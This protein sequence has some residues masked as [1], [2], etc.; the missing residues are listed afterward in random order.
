[1]ART[2]RVQNAAQ[3]AILDSFNKICLRHQ[4]WRVWQDF[5]TIAA[6]DISCAVDKSTAKKRAKMR[7]EA[8]KAYSDAE[9]SLMADMLSEIVMSMEANPD[10]DCLGELFMRLELGNEY[11]GQFF[12][13]YDVCA[14][15]A[16]MNTPNLQDMLSEKAWI[17]ASDPACGA[18]ALL[19][20]LANEC[21]AQGV[22]YQTSVLF[23]AQDI[24]FIAGCMC[25]IQLSLL[26]C[27]GYVTIE[28]TLTKPQ[29]CIGGKVL[30]PVPGENIWYT[31]MYFRDIW[32]WRRTFAIADTMF[33]NMEH[34]RQEAPQ[35]PPAPK[36]PELHEAKHGQ[37]SLF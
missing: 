22:N 16:K 21:R 10:Q 6:A 28:N 34:A 31:P 13:P 7:E 18:G 4:R 23:C 29:T 30:L 9:L 15:M 19:I 5:V 36:M 24:D 3:K 17:S 33:Q 25:Y 26:G 8:A 27:A 12:T 1:M 37:L 11:K 14:C 32:H 35:E 2:I 20:A